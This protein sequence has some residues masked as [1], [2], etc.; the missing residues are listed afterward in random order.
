ML[1]GKPGYEGLNMDGVEFYQVEID[2]IP[3]A[4]DRRVFLFPVGNTCTA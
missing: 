2:E 4:G 1:D 3:V